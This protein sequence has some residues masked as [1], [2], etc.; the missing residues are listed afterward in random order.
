MIF[1]LEVGTKYY[2]ANSIRPTGG[3]TKL[4]NYIPNV[5]LYPFKK[6]FCTG[7]K[8]RFIQRQMSVGRSYTET[9]DIKVGR[10]NYL[11]DLVSQRGKLSRNRFG[12]QIT[13]IS[14]SFEGENGIGAGICNSKSCQRNIY[15]TITLYH[16]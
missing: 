2:T 15:S 4:E 12:K 9:A 14:A 16:D 11:D 3:F 1:F 8:L 7:V 13:S 5:K 10:D 6:L